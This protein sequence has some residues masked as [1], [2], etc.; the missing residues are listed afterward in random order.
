MPDEAEAVTIFNPTDNDINIS[1]YYLSDHPEY[2]KINEGDSFLGSKDFVINL[3]DQ[4][5]KSQDS[6]VIAFNEGYESFY[7]GN[8]L[9]LLLFIIYKQ[10][11]NVK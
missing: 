3:P 1:N 7:L 11:M 5:I 10:F 6:L 2:Y 9:L 8:L 4:I